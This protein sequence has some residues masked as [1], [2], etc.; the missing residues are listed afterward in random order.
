MPPPQAA[1]KIG[2]RVKNP[3]MLHFP[4]CQ[5][6]GAR[7]PPG[8][9]CLFP[10]PF[11]R[12]HRLPAATWA[13][14]TVRSSHCPPAGSS[15]LAN[16]LLVGSPRRSGRASAAEDLLGGR[17]GQ[18]QPG[19]DGISRRAAAASRPPSKPGFPKVGHIGTEP[20]RVPAA[21]PNRPLLPWLPGRDPATALDCPPR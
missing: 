15:V 7:P 1:Q 5:H 3:A 9:N 16:R 10:E 19:T 14:L 20:P 8:E 17:L 6:R 18:H 12:H 21:F 4:S 11:Q 2:P 13:H